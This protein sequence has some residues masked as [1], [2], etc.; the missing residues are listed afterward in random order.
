MTGYSCLDIG[1]CHRVN[2][3]EIVKEHATLSAAASVGNRVGVEITDNQVNRAADRGCRVSTCSHFP[4]QTVDHWG[5]LCDA[6]AK[7]MNDDIHG[8]IWNTKNAIIDATISTTPRI[9]F[10][11]AAP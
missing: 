4:F 5:E 3:L 9:G 1:C 2:S 11:F 7:P 8:I 6:A 10:P